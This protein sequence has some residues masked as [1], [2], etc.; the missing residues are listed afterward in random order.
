MKIQKYVGLD[1]HKDT[2]MIAI[3]EGDRT[4]EVRL[5][6]QISSDL[7]ALDGARQRGDGV[8]RSVSGG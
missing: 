5:Y 4:G 3:A 6:G 7:G 8:A 2:T 1:V